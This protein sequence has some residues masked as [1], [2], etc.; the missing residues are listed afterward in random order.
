MNINYNNFKLFLTQ[1]AE[2]TDEEF[3]LVV[4]YLET[5]EI[6]KGE[7]FIKEGIHCKHIAFI[8][9]GLFRVFLLK[10]GTE[11]NTC[12][13]LQNEVMSSFDSL[14]NDTFS[15]ENIQALEDSF[16]VTISY[17]NLLLLSNK[18]KPWNFIRNIMLQKECLRLANR[19]NQMSFE[20]AQE[21]YEYLM[22]NQPQIIQRVSNIHIA[23]YLGITRETLSRVRAKIAK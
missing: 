7:Y 22:R 14:V 16:I 12:F 5:K 10:K 18:S 11:L 2:M 15:K 21:K 13:C 23:S 9:E 19:A 20:T 3:E 1:I 4:P 6:K 17:R 8:N